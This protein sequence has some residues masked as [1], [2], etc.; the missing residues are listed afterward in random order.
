MV[1][2]DPERR[3]VDIAITCS[4]FEE[5]LHFYKDILGF[6]VAVDTEISGEVA[7]RTSGWRHEGSIR[8]GCRRA[9]A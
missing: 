7:T 8:Y 1:D 2:I 4:N 5:S 6:E 9:T 3:A